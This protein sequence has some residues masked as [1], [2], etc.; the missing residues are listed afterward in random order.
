M[1]PGRAR[2]RPGQQRCGQHGPSAQAPITQQ[3]CSRDAQAA[4]CCP[5]DTQGPPW[6]SLPPGEVP[7]ATLLARGQRGPL[8]HAHTSTHAH[9][10][11]QGCTPTPPGSDSARGSLSVQAAPQRLWVSAP[12][13]PAAPPYTHTG[14]C[15]HSTYGLG[16]AAERARS[17]GGRLLSGKDCSQAPATPASHVV[18]VPV[19]AA[20]LLTQ[21]PANGS[22]RWPTCWVPAT[23][24]GDQDEAP[25]FCV[26]QPWPSRPS[27][28]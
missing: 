4:G 14:F 20:P 13:P 28:E 22:R 5:R 18:L 2:S 27:G 11:V 9:V 17:R 1:T 3:H 24:V 21:C 10:C 16:T 19:P 25:G 15:R 8:A 7:S 12:L 6:Y 26:P 23:P